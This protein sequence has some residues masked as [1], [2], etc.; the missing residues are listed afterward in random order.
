[1]RNQEEVAHGLQNSKE[2][3]CACMCKYMQDR[4]HVVFGG[5]GVPQVQSH[6]ALL[7]QIRRPACMISQSVSAD[8]Y[9]SLKPI[10][11]EV[12]LDKR[13]VKSRKYSYGLWR[14]RRR[15]VT[16]HRDLRHKMLFGDS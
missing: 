14:V 10:T 11:W 9:V 12:L 1:M 8:Q 4:F 2:G 3:L 13:A 16:A 15:A 7:L 5:I 6:F